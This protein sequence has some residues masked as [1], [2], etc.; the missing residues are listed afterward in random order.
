MVDCLVYEDSG[1]VCHKK[2][3]NN[4]HALLVKSGDIVRP[5]EENVL[6]QDEFICEETIEGYVNCDTNPYVSFSNTLKLKDAVNT[7]KNVLLKSG[8]FIIPLLK[9]CVESWCGYS[10]KIP[11]STRRVYNY[12]PPGG[13]V[14][15]CY[16]AKKQQICKEAPELRHHLMQYNWLES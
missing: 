8:S 14:Y 15:R 13:K 12:E 7:D 11:K 10:G 1:R 6:S 4:S 9:K 5:K 3:D 2:E 16:Y